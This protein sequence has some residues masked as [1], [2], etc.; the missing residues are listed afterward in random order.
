[1]TSA[2]RQ[3]LHIRDSQAQSQRSV[4]ARRRRRGWERCSTFS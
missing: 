4:A 1:M 2:V 3:P